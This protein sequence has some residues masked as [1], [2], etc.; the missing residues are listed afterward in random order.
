MFADR[1]FCDKFSFAKGERTTF[2]FAKKKKVPKKKLASPS[3]DPLS[4]LCFEAMKPLRKRVTSDTVFL[5]K[6]L[7]GFG[8]F[9]VLRPTWASNGAFWM[10]V[11]TKP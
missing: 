4:A 11:P 2:F 7:A 1:A 5:P 8:R 9:P 10:G 6:P 3:L